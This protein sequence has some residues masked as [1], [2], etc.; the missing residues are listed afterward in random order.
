[1][2]DAWGQESLTLETLRDVYANLN[3]TAAPPPAA[4]REVARRR[5][6]RAVAGAVFELGLRQC[7]PKVIQ[8]LLARGAAAGSLT[9]EHIKSH[10]QKYRQHHDR[11]R[12]PFRDHFERCLRAP[13]A[14]PP[15]PAATPP[16]RG[17]EAIEAAV[18]RAPGVLCEL[19]AVRACLR[20]D[21]D[22]ALAEHRCLADE[23][24]ALAPGPS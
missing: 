11:S 24:A 13:A 6:E 14:A 10:L 1:M 19:A 2:A 23:L 7:S 20:R 12:Q 5:A 4:A 15:P 8:G 21:V 17:R 22:A 3:H 9:T 16:Q 18:G